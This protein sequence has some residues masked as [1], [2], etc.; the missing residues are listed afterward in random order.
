MSRRAGTEP[1]ETDETEE[2]QTMASVLF[3]VTGADHLTLTDGTDHPTGYWAEEVVT[4]LEI[5]TRA[6]HRV[7]VATPG[8]VLPPADPASLTAAG[9][10]GEEAAAQLR[11]VVA[12]SPELAHPADL[13]GIDLATFD[14]VFVPGGH[15]PMQD[16]AV[17]AVSG[18]LLA[19]A[20][21]SGKPLAVVCHGP[22]ALLAA[23]GS[24]GRNAFAG[25]TI[26]AFTNEE[27]RQGGLADRVPWLLATRLAEA[28]L[29][30]RA[31]EP[32]VPHLETDGNL[33]TGQNPASS[34]PLATAL[35]DRLS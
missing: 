19:D 2:E 8:G 31:G 28:G 23:T 7:T 24:D 11:S 5:L 13:A 32:W 27:E 14:A 21:S 30:V 33:L 26:T 10:G 35:A 6:G 20:L 12:S 15:G 16:L 17:D 25:R 34:A 4:P 9:A 22:A 18:R 29:T 3:V 1:D